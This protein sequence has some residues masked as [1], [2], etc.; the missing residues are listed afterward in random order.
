MKRVLLADMAAWK[1]SRTL[2]RAPRT[3]TSFGLT[4]LSVKRLRRNEYKL[5]LDRAKKNMPPG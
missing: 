2:A 5:V 4:M 1:I 3:P